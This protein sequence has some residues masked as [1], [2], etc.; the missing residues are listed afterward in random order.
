MDAEND[1]DPALIHICLKFLQEKGI[2]QR[3]IFCEK[4]G[5]ESLMLN[6]KIVYGNKN[7]TL[8]SNQSKL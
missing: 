7:W 1:L 4:R 2:D 6:Q 8:S 5:S 3:D